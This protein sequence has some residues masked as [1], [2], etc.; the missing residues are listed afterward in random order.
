MQELLKSEHWHILRGYGSLVIAY[1]NATQWNI[2]EYPETDETFDPAWKW[3]VD[4]KSR[5]LFAWS[6]DGT[7]KKAYMVQGNPAIWVTTKD[8]QYYSLDL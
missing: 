1:K 4:G 7:G 8:A 3:V 5:R 6:D 2:K